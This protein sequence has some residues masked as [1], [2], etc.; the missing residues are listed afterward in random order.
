MVVFAKTTPEHARETLNSP[1]ARATWLENCAILTP[2]FLKILF[3]TP[4]SQ[5]CS[6]I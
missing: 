4:N 3:V 5:K 2:K 6:Q 1:Y